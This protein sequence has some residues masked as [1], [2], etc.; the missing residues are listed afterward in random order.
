M[1]AI[2]ALVMP[3][4]AARTGHLGILRSAFGA[5]DDLEDDRIDHGLVHRLPRIRS[6]IGFPRL[7]RVGLRLCQPFPA[8]VP[9]LAT[10]ARPIPTGQPFDD[11]RVRTGTNRAWRTVDA[12]K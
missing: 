4:R 3:D 1:P 2:P 5:L 10:H 12:R 6:H 7:D 8:A 11:L 9:T